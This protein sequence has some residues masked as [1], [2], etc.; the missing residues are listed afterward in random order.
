MLTRDCN[1]WRI[2]RKKFPFKSY[3]FL[4]YA[5]HA[6]CNFPFFT[7]MQATFLVL[8]SGMA[9][10]IA[11]SLWWSAKRKC[12]L[13]VTHIEHREREGRECARDQVAYITWRG[14]LSAPRLW[15]IREHGVR[16]PRHT[17]HNM[18]REVSE[19]RELE[20]GQRSHAH[21]RAIVSLSRTHS[22]I[23]SS[24]KRTKIRIDLFVYE[25]S[26]F[27]I[28]ILQP[29]CYRRPTQSCIIPGARRGQLF[30]R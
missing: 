16:C 26:L 29:C 3:N 15:H 7:Q 17:T 24:T 6:S 19:R 23:F 18:Q 8:F 9:G 30:F 25:V 1:A 20:K 5:I 12:C 13:R 14:A 2:N 22:V 27:L 28:F 10:P 21:A 4:V 11:R